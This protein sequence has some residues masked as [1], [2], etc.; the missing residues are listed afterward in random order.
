MIPN[1]ENFES[2]FQYIQAEEFLTDVEEKVEHMIKQYH[3][4]TESVE[5][6]CG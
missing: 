1:R 2:E 6:I 5:M 4:S 3:I